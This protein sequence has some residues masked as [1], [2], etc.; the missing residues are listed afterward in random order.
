MGEWGWLGWV[1]AL[2]VSIVAIRGNVNFD[3]NAWLKDRR[4]EKKERLRSLCPH[5]DLTHER[6]APAIRSTFISPS[7]TTAWQCQLCGV[8]TYD[9]L[10][11]DEQ[12]QYWASNPDELMRRLKKAEKLARKLGHMA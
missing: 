3:V 2:V 6:G 5:V 7:G 9:R 1:V 11:V 10:S 12:A 4:E 8:S